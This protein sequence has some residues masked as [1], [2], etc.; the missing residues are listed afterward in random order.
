MGEPEE[1]IQVAE[2]ALGDKG[3]I[4][5]VEVIKDVEMGSE[6]VTE[7]LSEEVNQEVQGESEGEEEV[8]ISRDG[9]TTEDDVFGHRNQEDEKV[10]EDDEMRRKKNEVISINYRCLLRKSPY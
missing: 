9:E 10:V 6:E 3:G 8:L 2:V 5:M 7:L 1:V 4:E